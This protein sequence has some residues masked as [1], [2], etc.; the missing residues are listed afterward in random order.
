[1]TKQLNWPECVPWLSAGDIVLASGLGTSPGSLL[2]RIIG[3][4][5]GYGTGTSEAVWRIYLLRLERVPC[6]PKAFAN[7]W[8]RAID[9]L[10]VYEPASKA[11]PCDLD[12]E[13]PRR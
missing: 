12:K 7:R 3:R 2:G 4:V 5:F 11:I 8:N 1:M 9:Q 6:D 13:W 10:G